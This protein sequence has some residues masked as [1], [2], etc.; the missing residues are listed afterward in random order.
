[1]PEHMLC[2]LLKQSSFVSAIEYLVGGGA[3]KLREKLSKFLSQMESVPEKESYEF[4]MSAQMEEVMEKFMD[5]P[6]E[7]K[8]DRL[9]RAKELYRKS[10]QKWSRP[11]TPERR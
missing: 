2:A 3:Q 8:R 6:C 9:E 11:E 1:M 4:T 7:L 10:L 5:F